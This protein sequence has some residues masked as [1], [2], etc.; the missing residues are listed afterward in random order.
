MQTEA[1][2]GCEPGKAGN[3]KRGL[4]AIKEINHGGTEGTEA[5]LKSMSARVRE[6]L[7]TQGGRWRG[8]DHGLHGWARI[9][10]KIER[11]GAVNLNEV[12]I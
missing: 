5:R 8:L 9:R 1:D 7:G 10:T 6:N 11:A 12:G 3:T 2:D 4:A